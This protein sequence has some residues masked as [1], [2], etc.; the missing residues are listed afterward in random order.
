MLK[1]LVLLR[2]KDVVKM[3]LL[4]GICHNKM[5]TVL[6]YT[7]NQINCDD[8]S[9]YGDTGS[10]TKDYYIQEKDGKLIANTVYKE[11]NQYVQNVRNGRSYDKLLDEPSKVYTIE[12]YYQRNKSFPGLKQ[13]FV[14]VKMS[15]KC[16]MKICFV[17]FTVTINLPLMITDCCLMAIQQ[18][19]IILKRE[20]RK[21]F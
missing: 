10:V 6:G 12:I 20:H 19:Q 15:I 5:Y 7:I 8:N 14:K 9:A 13:M 2:E 4:K 17:L 1:T 18:K 3:A 11:G 16:T 21:Q